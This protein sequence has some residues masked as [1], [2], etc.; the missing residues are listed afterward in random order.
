MSEASYEQVITNLPPAVRAAIEQGDP[1]AFQCALEELPAEQAERIINELKQ[2]GVIVTDW[3]T[4]AQFQEL[5]NEFDLLIKAIV[6]VAE[7][8]QSQRTEVLAVLPRLEQAGI[9]LGDAVTRIWAGERQAG[10]LT[11]NLDPNSTRLVFHIL[12][13]IREK[14]TESIDFDLQMIVNSIPTEVLS[15]IEEQDEVAFQ[16]AMENLAPAERQFVANQ[17]AVLQAH[18]DREAEAWLAGLPSDVRLAVIEQDPKRLK[19]VLTELEPAQALEILPQLEASGLLVEPAPDTSKAILAEFEP[20]ILAVVSIAQG[21]QQARPQVEAWLDEI[22]MQ[23]WR[24]KEPIQRI[25][26]GERQPDNITTGLD[27]QDQMVVTEI[28]KLL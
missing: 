15:A 16:Q 24:L 14:D 13:L 20:M 28:L 25:W 7:G 8:D 4:N 6:S 11:R 2:V 27:Y 22:E 23:G 26:T 9:H 17:L 19:Q 1:A 3:L 21:N 5:L 10:E 12:N 18:A